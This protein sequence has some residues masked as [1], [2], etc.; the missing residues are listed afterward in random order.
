MAIKHTN[1]NRDFEVEEY[2]IDS[3]ADVMDLPTENIGWGSTALC[4]EN[5][6]VYI[7]NSSYE[8]VPLGGN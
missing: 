5:G 7:L 8:W 2:V 1:D 4:I 3:I 6:L